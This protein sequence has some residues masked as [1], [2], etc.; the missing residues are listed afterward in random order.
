MVIEQEDIYW[1]DFGSEC[2]AKW[3]GLWLYARE[4]S[5][6]YYGPDVIIWW[7]T[8]RSIETGAELDSAHDYPGYPSTGEEARKCA[9]AAARYWGIKRGYS[10]HSL[11]ELHV[12]GYWNASTKRGRNKKGDLTKATRKTLFSER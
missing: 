12:R 9:E 4:T 3:N 8:V 11:L 6:E 7:W 5:W 10:R 1:R 2:R